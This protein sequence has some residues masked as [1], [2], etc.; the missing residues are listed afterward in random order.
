MAPPPS[1]VPIVGITSSLPVASMSIDGS[2]V[3]EADSQ[4]MTP[5]YTV[6][7]KHHKIALT[8]FQS[9][10]SPSRSTSAP[11]QSSMSATYPTLVVLQVTI[12]VE[13]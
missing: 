13:A 10:K 3:T 4:E 7:P 11:G 1:T 8:L 12:P 9:P 2:E 6:I 5:P